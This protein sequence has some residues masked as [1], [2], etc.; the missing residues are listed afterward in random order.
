MVESL[1]T[2]PTLKAT[3]KES[4]LYR[5][6]GVGTTDR[7]FLIGH[8]DGIPLNDPY[9]VADMQDAVNALGADTNS[10]LLRGLFEAYFAGARDMWLIAAAPMS[11]YEPDLALRDTAYYQTYYDRLNVTYSIIEQ[12]DMAQI[13]V[14]IEAPFNTNVDFLG[15]L[16]VHCANSSTISGSVHL[17]F[18]GTRGVLTPAMVNA[19]SNDARIPRLQDAGK[20]VTIF[21]GDVVYNFPEMEG[22]HTASGVVA[23]AAAF[24]QLPLNRG[25]T[26]RSLRNVVGPVGPD[27]S[28]DQIEQLAQAKINPIIRTVKGKRGTSYEAVIASDNTLAMDGSDYWSLAQMKLVSSVSASIRELG[29]KQLGGIGLVMFKNDVIQYLNGLFQADVL[30]NYTIDI[31]RDPI[32]RTKVLVYLTLSPYLGLRQIFVQIEVGPSQE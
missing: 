13:T 15:Q 29:K 25:L 10:P 17:G 26:Y 30:R 16:V 28:K 20:L 23:A 1:K 14:P 21:A 4:A 6:M 27:L 31:K 3:M 12:W 5:T 24:A 22:T 19:M 11:E 7:I 8:A 32:D 9:P 2:A 18:I